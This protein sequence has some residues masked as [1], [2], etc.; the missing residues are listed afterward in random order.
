MGSQP[1]T[2]AFEVQRN[3][4]KGVDI[5]ILMMLDGGCF[6][7]GGGVGTGKEVMWIWSVLQVCSYIFAATAGEL[8]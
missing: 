4:G 8:G 3:Y 2:G 6:F 1:L 7:G 5:K